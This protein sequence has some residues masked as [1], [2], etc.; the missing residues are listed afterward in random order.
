MTFR[1]WAEGQSPSRYLLSAG[2]QLYVEPPGHREHQEFK[3]SFF[4]FPG[5]LVI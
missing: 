5:A 4:A 1:N 3:I 2:E